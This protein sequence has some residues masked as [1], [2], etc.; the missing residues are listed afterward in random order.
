MAAVTLAKACRLTSWLTER[1]LKPGFD[2]SVTSF[3]AF[4]LNCPTSSA[5]E[6]SKMVEPSDSYLHSALRCARAI[7]FLIVAGSTAGSRPAFA[8][9]WT[10]GAGHGEIIVTG[11][12]FETSHI[13]SSDGEI[14]P[15]GYGGKFQQI[16]IN[17]Y[18]EYGLT[19]RNTLV[20]NF[21]AQHLHYADQYH[22]FNSIGMGDVEVALRRRLKSPG[23]PWAVSGQVLIL[24][25]AYSATT[26]PAPGNHQED[27][28]GRALVGRPIPWRHA[29]WDTEAAYRFR[30]G[31][32]ADQFRAEAAAG[33]DVFERTKLI[34][35]FYAIKSMQ[36]GAPLSPSSNP[37]AQS[38]FDLYKSEVSLVFQV[39]PRTR[40][41]A[42]WVDAFSGRNTGHGSS[43][44]I[45]LWRSF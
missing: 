43:A 8:G 41:Q 28:E 27:F 2:T 31:A 45:A 19:S 44:L 1:L 23:S 13:F 17:P 33:F 3:L 6:V 16:Q 36:N 21:W 38:D 30:T 39:H 10:Q 5:D 14:Q 42:G 18:F 34:G 26:T 32:P 40:V 25:P 29:Y 24:F 12:Y 22:A 11:S 9:A 37:N 35:Q 7:I 4:D 15:F 20:V